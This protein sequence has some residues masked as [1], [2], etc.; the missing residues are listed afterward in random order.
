MNLFQRIEKNRFALNEHT[1]SFVRIMLDVLNGLPGGESIIPEFVTS[2]HGWSA[3]SSYT[4]LATYPLNPHYDPDLPHTPENQAKST[5][6][7]HHLVVVPVV[8]LVL[9]EEQDTWDECA[10][11]PE[12]WSLPQIPAELFFELN[13][14]NIKEFFV[15]HFAEKAKRNEEHDFQ[16]KWSNLYYSYTPEELTKYA[17]AMKA[18]EVLPNNERFNKTLEIMRAENE[19]N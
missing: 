1:N 16:S 15:N 6:F 18:A 19:Q 10:G 5:G 11:D 13:A 17:T 9:I 7:R 14:E 12:R 8:H 3:Q 4:E 2:Y